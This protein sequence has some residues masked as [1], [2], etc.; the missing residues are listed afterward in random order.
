M[1]GNPPGIATSMKRS[2]QY[3]LTIHQLVYF[4]RQLKKKV[5]VKLG[6]S[7]IYVGQPKIMSI[8]RDQG[9][10]RRDLSA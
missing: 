9:L 1:N 3:I 7:I 8:K 4:W 6:L 2:G 5:T 10:D